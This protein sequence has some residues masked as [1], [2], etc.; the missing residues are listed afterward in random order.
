ML[1]ALMEQVK[2]LLKMPYKR[3]SKW[4]GLNI[5]NILDIVLKHGILSKSVQLQNIPTINKNNMSDNL[6]F[7]CAWLLGFST[8]SKYISKLY[9][10]HS[11]HRI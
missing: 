3:N 5:F 7:I 8:K 11:Y 6:Y 4:Y 10:I 2:T 1:Y 9:C